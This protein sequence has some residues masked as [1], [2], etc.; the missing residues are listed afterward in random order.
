MAQATALPSPRSAPKFAALVSEKFRSYQR[1][2]DSSS[3][4]FSQRPM[5][6]RR[7]A[8]N[9]ERDQILVLWP[10]RNALL[11]VQFPQL[12]SPFLYLILREGLKMRRETNE[13]IKSE[14]RPPVN[15]AG[16]DDPIARAAR[17]RRAND[18]ADSTQRLEHS[19][20]TNAG[21]S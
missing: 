13:K 8:I 15:F 11:L 9:S 10:A 12:P 19:A 16:G 21:A 7:K 6:A 4:E 3:V 17:S 2:C 20:K 14:I 18:C 1:A 5:R